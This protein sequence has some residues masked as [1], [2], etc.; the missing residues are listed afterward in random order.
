ML[1]LHHFSCCTIIQS[2]LSIYPCNEI[3]ISHKKQKLPLRQGASLTEGQQFAQKYLLFCQTGCQASVCCTR[4]QHLRGGNAAS[5]AAIRTLRPAAKN[6]RISALCL[7]L[8]QAWAHNTLVGLYA[9]LV[10]GI[11]ICQLALI[12]DGKCQHVEELSQVVGI[13]LRQ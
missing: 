13:Q 11:H 9:R 2:F 10:E 6:G 4:Q 5:P 8:L 7:Y 3:E 1:K 12:G